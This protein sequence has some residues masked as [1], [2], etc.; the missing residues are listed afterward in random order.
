MRLTPRHVRAAYQMFRH[1]PPFHRWNLPE[2]ISLGVNSIRGE[3]GRYLY[4]NG[5]HRIEVSRYNV[6]C[7]S[8]LAVTMAHEIIHLRQQLT[9]TCND[10]SQHNLA[11]HR[12]ARHVCRSL[13]FDSK[14][15][16]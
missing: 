13:G 4:E 12:T 8:A 14:G 6:K 15:F 1:L 9:N 10:R 7:F 11:F 16:T 3:Y 5:K 2:N